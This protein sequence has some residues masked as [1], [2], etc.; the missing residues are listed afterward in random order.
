[1]ALA[2]D[3]PRDVLAEVFRKPAG[4]FDE[5]RTVHAKPGKHVLRE[6]GVSLSETRSKMQTQT[7]AQ[8]IQAAQQNL[9][10]LRDSLN[11]LAAKDELDADETKRY[12]E[13]LP[14]QIED[15]RRELEAH[16]RVERSLVDDSPTTITVVSRNGASR[17]SCCRRPTT[18]R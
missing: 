2:K 12:Q 11:E 3:Y 1:M 4:S 13:E 5:L 7:I 16:R 9:G 17:R 10:M 15:A 14:Q 18:R 8:K 6:G